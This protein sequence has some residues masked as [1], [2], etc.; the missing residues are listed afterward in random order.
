[1]N[2]VSNPSG[3][4]TQE[5]TCRQSRAA[6]D[7]EGEGIK[8]PQEA[9]NGVMCPLPL[10]RPAPWEPVALGDARPRG[11]SLRVLGAAFPGETPEA[12]QKRS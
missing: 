6:P 3:L 4:Q 11:C 8:S 12:E 1:M 5:E 2:I 9:D 10:P 7:P